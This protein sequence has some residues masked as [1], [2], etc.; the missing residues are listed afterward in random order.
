MRNFLSI[1]KVKVLLRILRLRCSRC[2]KS[3][4]CLFPCLVPHS[5]YSAKALGELVVRYFFE[6]KSCE[7]IGWE[8]SSEEGE[9][10]RHLVYRL[11]EGLCRKEDWI[12]RVAEKQ[13]LEQGE[14]LWKR[15]EPEPEEACSNARRVR[16]ETK[17][18]AMNRVKAALMKFRESTG[19]ALETIVS[20]LHEVSMQL[21]APFSLLSQAKVA[22]VKI[23]HKRGKA[24]F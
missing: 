16:S 23:P 21:S 17:K 2:K 6:D 5:S 19:Q 8:A 14:S 3:H 22:P 11:V 10:H 9:G 4:A 1:E 20:S 7:A 18:A 15:K 13:V 12:A 24:L